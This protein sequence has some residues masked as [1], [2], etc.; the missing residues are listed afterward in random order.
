MHACLWRKYL[1]KLEKRVSWSLISLNLQCYNHSLLSYNHSQV[2][3][4]LPWE[5]NSGVTFFGQSFS[6]YLKELQNIFVALSYTLLQNDN[7]ISIKFV[8]RLLSGGWQYSLAN[9]SNTATAKEDVKQKFS[10]SDVNWTLISWF[11]SSSTFSESST[12]HSHSK[13]TCSSCNYTIWERKKTGYSCTWIYFSI[14]LCIT[15]FI[16]FITSYRM[17]QTCVPCKVRRSPKLHRVRHSP[18]LFTRSTDFCVPETLIFPSQSTCGKGKL[19][20]ARF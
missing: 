5:S 13:M 14:Y 18:R 11:L 2:I 9:E 8:G 15:Y 12:T 6:L 4:N 17:R 7:F 1:N 10:C 19:V 3:Y 16:W 20:F